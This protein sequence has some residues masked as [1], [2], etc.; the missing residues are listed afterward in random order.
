MRCWATVGVSAQ[1]W[2]VVTLETNSTT[3]ALLLPALLP[4]FC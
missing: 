3:G 2:N 1:S 4:R